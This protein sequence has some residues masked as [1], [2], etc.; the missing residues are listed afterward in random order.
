MRDRKMAFDFVGTI[1]ADHNGSAAIRTRLDELL[2]RH[3]QN[4]RMINV[5]AGSTR[6]H[7][8]MINVEI[9]Q[10]PNTDVVASA[11]ALPFEDGSV[12]LA[13]TQEVLEHVA[14]P[15]AAMREIHRVLRPGGSAYVQ[16]PFIIG[17]HRCPDDFTRYTSQGIVELAR[18]AGFDDIELHTSVGPA[19]GAYRIGVEF[20]AILGSRIAPGLYRYAKG[21][22]AL[23]LFPL[24]W[25]DPLLRGHPQAYRI[26]G[27][28]FI[29]ATKR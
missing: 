12:D 22:A 1:Y 21:A 29:V 23:L 27:G 3:G 20:L 26:A 25:L 6:L 28:F 10:G 15:G 14:E 24:K 9:E 11:T 8:R 18:Q 16:L 7:E 2:A 13:V 5:G 19:V 17:D 4:G